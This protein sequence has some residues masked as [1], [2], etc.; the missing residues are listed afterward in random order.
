MQRPVPFL[1]NL[2]KILKHIKKRK[3][4]SRLF[5][6]ANVYF[7]DESRFGLMTIQRRVVAVRGVKPIVPFQH[8]FKNFYLFGAYSPKNGSHFTL[9]LPKCNSECFQLYLD[10][11]S[12][13][14]PQ[15]YKAI[16]LD[17]GAFHKAKSLKVPENIGL[18]FLP[19]YSPELNPA[20]KIWRHIKD[21]IANVAFATLDLLSEKVTEIV[22]SMAAQTIKSI[23]S[24]E[25]Y[26]DKICA[27]LQ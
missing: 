23:T 16:F 19:P 22:R 25:I 9:E 8:R 26:R 27:Y 4:V 7:Q 24:Y 15:E 11:F 1:K 21:K 13:K 20:E 17:N 2:S 6:S 10:E 18:Y 14:D 3:T 12:K 5:K